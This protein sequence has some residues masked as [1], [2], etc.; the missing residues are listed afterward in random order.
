MQLTLLQISLSKL[1]VY[2]SSNGNGKV[3]HLG[4]LLRYET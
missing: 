2:A 4:I 3:S 1:G